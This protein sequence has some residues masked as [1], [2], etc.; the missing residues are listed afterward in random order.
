MKLTVLYCD[1]FTTLLLPRLKQRFF[2]TYKMDVLRTAPSRSEFT[3]LS[4]HQSQTPPSFYDGPAILYHQSSGCT[5]KAS[6]RD[7]AAAAAFEGLV[8]SVEKKSN[9]PVNGHLSEEIP[10]GGEHEDESLDVEIPNLDIWVT[11]KSVAA[12]FKTP[13]SCFF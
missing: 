6:A 8:S 4:E 5:F 10:V 11:S 1:C 13:A 9:G 3:L 2:S 12:L 7:L